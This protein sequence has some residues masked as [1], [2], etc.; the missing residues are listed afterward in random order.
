MS[1]RN[2]RL[3]AILAEA[4]STI[5]DH[6]ASCLEVGLKDHSAEAHAAVG[7]CI[8]EYFQQLKALP[9]P[10]E[11]EAIMEALKNLFAN[12]DALIHTFGEGLL[13]T[14][15]RELLCPP[16]IDAGQAAGLDLSAFP[17]SDPTL[18]YRNF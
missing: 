10:A 12:L 8:L 18:L 2:D 9:E 6:W 16:I 11:Q 3:D 17:H 15:E 4:G 7:D 1:T 5:A 14:D 13:E